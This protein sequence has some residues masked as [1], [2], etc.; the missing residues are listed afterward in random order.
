MNKYASAKEKLV[1]YPNYFKE[2]KSGKEHG[3][4]PV[5]NFGTKS[6]DTN[7]KSGNAENLLTPGISDGEFQS[8]MNVKRM[9]LKFYAM[10]D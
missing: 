2:R 6:D 5:L 4:C 8:E 9:A 3:G 7:P 10:H 1:A